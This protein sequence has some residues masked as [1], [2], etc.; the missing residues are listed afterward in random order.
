MPVTCWLQR[1]LRIWQRFGLCGSSSPLKAANVMIGKCHNKRSPSQRRK[2]TGCKIS[3][4]HLVYPLL[5]PYRAYNCFCKKYFFQE[6]FSECQVIYRYCQRRTA[7][8]RT[9]PFSEK[10]VC[11]MQFDYPNLCF[12]NMVSHWT[13]KILPVG[14]FGVWQWLLAW[15]NRKGNS[16]NLREADQQAC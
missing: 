13:T 4:Y 1:K 12:I 14:W 6:C 2:V 15:M 3:K 10:W 11:N 7:L 8:K 16:T 9:L 5:G